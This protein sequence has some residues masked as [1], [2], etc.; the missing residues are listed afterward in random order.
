MPLLPFRLGFAAKVKTAIPHK[1]RIPKFHRQL[2]TLGSG[3]IA[4]KF[5]GTLNQHIESITQIGVSNRTE[6][7]P[8]PKNRRGWPIKSRWTG[9]LGQHRRALQSRRAMLRSDAI[10]SLTS[11]VFF[12][13]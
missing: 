11:G 10:P 5:V 13:P 8:L 9:S 2:P 7:R 4:S 3:R 6:A 12:H 1:P